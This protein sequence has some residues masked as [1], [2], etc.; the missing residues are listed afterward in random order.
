LPINLFIYLAKHAKLLGVTFDTHLNSDK[1]ISNV[2]SASYFHIR[3]L[4]HIRPYHDM[5][6]YQTIAGVIVGS[7][8]QYAKSI[9]SRN[10]VFSA[11]KMPW[12]ES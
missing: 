11:L 9:S 8:L 10:I 2:Y 3:A 1:P 7:R 4:R 5:E 12:Y 6:T